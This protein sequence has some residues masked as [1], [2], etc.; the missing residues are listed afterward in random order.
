MGEKHDCTGSQKHNPAIPETCEDISNS[1]QKAAG[2]IEILFTMNGSS[3][4]PPQG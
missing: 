2:K 3:E 1:Q 4:I